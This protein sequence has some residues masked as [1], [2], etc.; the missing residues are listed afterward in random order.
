MAQVR[1][2]LAPPDAEPRHAHALTWLGDPLGHP[3]DLWWAPAALAALDSALSES[4]PDIVVLDHLF[5]R[6][7]LPLAHAHGAAVVLNTHNVEGPL[8]AAIGATG[9]FAER[10]GL[11]AKVAERTRTVEAAAVAAADEVWACSAEDAAALSAAYAPPGLV[12]VV[13]NVVDVPG[14][15][16]PDDGRNRD[17]IL[18]AGALG[19]PPNRDAVDFLL[20]EVLPRL[21]ETAPAMTLTVL[22]AAPPAQLRQ[23]VEAAGATL[24]GTVPSAAPYFARAGVLAVPL[25]TGGGT[26]FKV[27]EAFAAGLPVVSTAKG[28]EGLSLVDGTHFLRAETASEFSAALC[29]LLAD[30]RLR[31]EMRAAA[32]AVAL[33]RYSTEAVAP[34]VAAAL[35]NLA[36]L[37][38]A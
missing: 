25:T 10:P 34:V 26:R 38:S 31:A 16:A 3:S 24:T 2:W 17:E 6:R 22:G 18:Y 32:H 23:A 13:P 33:E 20:R 12:R 4:R 19:Y 5:T 36:A 37:R 8:A 30:D 35:T 1:T 28:V 9:R 11:A 7:A 29:R 27:L 15:L 21:R 14:A